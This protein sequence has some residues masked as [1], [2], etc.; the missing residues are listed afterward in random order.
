MTKLRTLLLFSV[1]GVLALISTDAFAQPASAT[2]RK[3]VE[4]RKVAG[5]EKGPT[6]P[7][8]I[9]AVATRKVVGPKKGPICPHCTYKAVT[10]RKTVGATKRPLVKATKAKAGPAQTKAQPPKPA[11]KPA[12]GQCRPADARPAT[13]TLNLN[14]SM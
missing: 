2:G 13:A 6:C 5:P 11:K 4:T 8:C 3:A 10:A 7:H 14:Q 1:L 9:K 12:T